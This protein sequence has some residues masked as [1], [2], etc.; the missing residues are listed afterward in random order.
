MK[1]LKSLAVSVVALL[2]ATTVQAKEVTLLM[3]W[4][5]QGNQSVFW[6]AM[7]DNDEHD[8]KIIVKP[9]GPGVNLSLIHI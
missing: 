1:L 5:P 3:D 9:G 7:L 8:L 4:F 2:F 6:Q